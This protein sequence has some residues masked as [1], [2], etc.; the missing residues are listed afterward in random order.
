MKS[1]TLAIVSRCRPPRIIA[2]GERTGC[3]LRWEPSKSP[4]RHNKA[5]CCCVPIPS[6]RVLTIPGT[7]NSRAHHLSS[8][9]PFLS[10]FFSLSFYGHHS[11]LERSPWY[12]T[13][14]DVPLNR[15]NEGS[16]ALF[17][18]PF[19]SRAAIVSVNH[20]R[21]PPFRETET[22]SRTL[23]RRPAVDGLVSQRD[24]RVPAIFV[25]LSLPFSAIPRSGGVARD[26]GRRPT[27]LIRRDL[28]EARCRDRSA[29]GR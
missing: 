1:S 23:A 2:R 13:A 16:R 22:F 29:L 27:S 28:C 15:V 11:A 26:R 20:K 3:Q 14:N 24:G 19:P 18:K 21:R 6:R 10:F 17:A 12:T 7:P 8:H 5:R 25:S 9:P 4:V